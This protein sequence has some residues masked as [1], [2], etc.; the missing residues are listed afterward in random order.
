MTSP[1]KAILAEYLGLTNVVGVDR[2]GASTVEGTVS[3]IN[4]DTCVIVSALPEPGLAMS[5]EV[6]YDDI[7]GV[8]TKDTDDRGW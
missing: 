6:A 3:A 1:Y 7:R 5:T 4:E 8:S 2:D